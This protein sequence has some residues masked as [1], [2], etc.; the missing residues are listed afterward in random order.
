MKKGINFIKE[1]PFT[2]LKL[3]PV[4][5]VMPFY[6]FDGK[7]YKLN[8]LSKYNLIFG[9]VFCFSL[10]G[11]F[12]IIK[13]KKK[14]A[15]ILFIPFLQTLF[16]CIIFYG[17]P[18]YRVPLEPILIIL[19]SYGFFTLK[20]NYKQKFF[21]LISIILTTNLILFFFSDYITLLLKEIMHF[22]VKSL[23]RG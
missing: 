5:I 18:Q 14:L 16:T 11:I 1:N 22:I 13:N 23:P 4:K 2:F 19:A 17:K 15:F 6:P 9:L 12:Y 20:E 21:F 10:L 8:L 7:W 3:I